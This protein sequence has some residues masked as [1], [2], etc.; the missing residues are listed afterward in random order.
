MSITLQSPKKRMFTAIGPVA[1]PL[2]MIDLD[3]E[4]P[5]LAHLESKLTD[6]EMRTYIYEQEDGRRLFKQLKQDETIVEEVWLQ[7][8]GNRYRVKEGNR[9]VVTSERIL[10]AIESGKLVGFNADDWQMIPAKIFRDNIT[11]KEIDMFLGTLHITGR[12]DWS[13]SNKGQHIHK[14]I[15]K[16]TETVDTVAEQLG[17]TAGVVEKSFQAFKM[18]KMFGKKY[19]D[20]KDRHGS[21]RN[22]V[23]YYSY[24]DEV[25]K[26]PNLRQ[27]I[28]E[29][30][31]NLDWLMG[32]IYENKFQNHREIRFLGEIVGSDPTTRNRSLKVLDSKHGDIKSAYDDFN[33]DG[34]KRRWNVLRSAYRVLE[35]FSREQLD[36]SSMDPE[37]TELLRKINLASKKLSGG[38]VNSK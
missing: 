38:G 14:M 10:K 6:E 1:V 33:Q 32:L 8:I 29:N 18:T 11:D 15:T 35:A 12:R 36:I 30:P 28:E 3:P 4:N 5:R 9:R 17:L 26:S 2:D 21:I 27:W 37:Y 20:G 34:G 23:H 13:A 16:Y 19:G 22:Y 7:K 25:M 31:S 24:F